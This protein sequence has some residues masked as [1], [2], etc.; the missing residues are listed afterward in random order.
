[1]ISDALEARLAALRAKYVRTFEG[2]ASALDQD[3]GALG[4]GDPDAAERIRRRAH[5]L[6]G[7]AGSYSLGDVQ[8]EAEAVEA[9]ANEGAAD[10]DLVGGTHALVAAL[11]SSAGE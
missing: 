5:R 7:T 1:M 3:I 6:A 8:R 10:A 2:E 4:S 9:L 11:R